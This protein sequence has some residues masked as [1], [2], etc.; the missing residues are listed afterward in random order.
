MKQKI[1]LGIA[2]AIGFILL[3][4]CYIVV[5]SN[6][7]LVH[8]DVTIRSATSNQTIGSLRD[9]VHANGY[10]VKRH[11][12]DKKQ[13][14]PTKNRH[15]QD[16]LSY[17]FYARRYDQAQ[18]VIY[19]QLDQL[20]GELGQTLELHFLTASP[21]ICRTHWNFS[22]LFEKKN[23]V[24]V[25]SITAD[26]KDKSPSKVYEYPVDQIPKIIKL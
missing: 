26:G 9:D 4:F 23:G 6:G 10:D 20:T 21:I 13:L 8:G 11:G 19:L 7:T 3:S 18:I 24:D 1:I 12:I 2:I 22:I 14:L 15:K 5:M 16:G 25:V 17:S